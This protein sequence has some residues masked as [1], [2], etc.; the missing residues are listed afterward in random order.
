KGEFFRAENPTA[1]QTIFDK[2]S[3]YEKSEILEVK[4]VQAKDFYR[5]YL[6]WG[7]IFWLL[8]LALKTTFM[9]NALED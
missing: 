6:I 9:N 1:L 8:W 3:N 5:I 2:I 4:Y 7:I